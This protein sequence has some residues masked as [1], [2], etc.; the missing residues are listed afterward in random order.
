MRTHTYL[1]VN[2]GPL[3]PWVQ[4]R[5]LFA[6]S[7]VAGNSTYSVL[8]VESDKTVSEIFQLFKE[9]SISNVAIFEATRNY[10]GWA[11]TD[12]WTWMRARFPLNDERKVA[13]KLDSLIGLHAVK[14]DIR[15]LETL[16]RVQ[17]EKNNRQIS[18]PNL[19]LHSLFLGPPGTGKTT[20][21]RIL[22]EMLRDL[23]VLK[24]G[25]V[26]EV[27]RSRL[28]AGYVGQTAIKTREAFESAMDGVLF[29]DEAY[30]L[31]AGADHGKDFGPEAI[32]TLLKLMEDH[33]D[34]VVVVVA[35]YEQR[36]RTFIQS[37]PGLESRFS[38]YFNFPN[39]SAEE[40]YEIFH[41]MCTENHYILDAQAASAAR[42]L[43]TG[44]HK[45]S[46]NES[47]GNGRDVRNIFERV[48]IQQSNRLGRLEELKEATDSELVE[49]QKEDI[50]EAARHFRIRLPRFLGRWSI[51]GL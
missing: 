24:K 35:G 18:S 48:C 8:A 39:Y 43:F 51:L 31:A 17:N 6:N 46:R 13:E 44:I 19:A 16:I 28:V 40:L 15:E 9:S 42:R 25:H 27:D 20:I 29:I 30:T 7:A 11:S 1:L 45:R 26:V 14:R 10:G 23:G 47:F 4:V 12:F 22:G 2:T 5:K 3:A 50:T 41:G 38:R 33:R 49:L 36:M 37:N 21:A 34:R 32:D